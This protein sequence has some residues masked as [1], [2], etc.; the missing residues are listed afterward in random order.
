[1]TD[2]FLQKV[3]IGSRNHSAALAEYEDLKLRFQN[4]KRDWSNLIY[5]YT[6]SS[7]PDDNLSEAVE[8]SLR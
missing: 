6:E 5:W 1:M 8:L 7:L 3:I 4:L 2:A